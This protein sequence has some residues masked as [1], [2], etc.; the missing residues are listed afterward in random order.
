MISWQCGQSWHP[1]QCWQPWQ[2]ESD[3]HSDGHS[4]GQWPPDVTLITPMAFGLRWPVCQLLSARVKTYNWG[5]DGITKADD[6]N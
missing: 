4:D 1:W 5:I 3:G 6:I 2:P